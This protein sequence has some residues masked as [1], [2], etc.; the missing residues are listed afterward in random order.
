MK[1]FRDRILDG[2]D[3]ETFFVCADE[4]EGRALMLALLGQM[5]FSDTDVVFARHA[6]PGARVRG[7]AYV[8]R[9]AG[10]YTWLDQTE[11]KE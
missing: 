2:L 1:D 7:R 11:A 5:G 3:V 4:A 6:G 8:N 9:P 10:S